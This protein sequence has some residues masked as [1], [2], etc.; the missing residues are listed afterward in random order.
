MN[1]ECAK[2]KKKKTTAID[3]LNMNQDSDELNRNATL[4][5]LVKSV[6]QEKQ[7]MN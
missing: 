1:S 5:N 2:K 4:I 3:L 7:S 6:V